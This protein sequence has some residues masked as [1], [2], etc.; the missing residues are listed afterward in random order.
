MPLWPYWEKL[1]NW[2][3]IHRKWLMLNGAFLIELKLFFDMCTD[4]GRRL[5][6]HCDE[7][8]CVLLEF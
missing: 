3:I 8:H 5:F 4:Y 7:V 1:A 2:D 6:C